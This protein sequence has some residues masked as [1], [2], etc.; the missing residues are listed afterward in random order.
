MSDVTYN[1]RDLSLSLTY[2]HFLYLH[3]QE[4]VRVLNVSEAALRTRFF[5]DFQT[6]E[7]SLSLQIQGYLKKQDQVHREKMSFT[8]GSFLTFNIQ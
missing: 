2:T 5:F 7:P 3:S 6:A 8:K 4:N 1:H